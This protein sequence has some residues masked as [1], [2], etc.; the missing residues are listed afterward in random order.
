MGGLIAKSDLLQT[1]FGW[2]KG[3]RRENTVGSQWC[4]IYIYNINIHNTILIYIY[5]YNNKHETK[6]RNYTCNDDV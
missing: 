4:N 5:L 3:T 1:T 6:A 2:I